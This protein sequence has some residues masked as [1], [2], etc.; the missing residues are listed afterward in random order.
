MFSYE[1][2]SYL[3]SAAAGLDR[4]NDLRQLI[5]FSAKPYQLYLATLLWQNC[6]GLLAAASKPYKRFLCSALALSFAEGE[7]LLV[8]GFKRALLLIPGSAA[9]K[10]LRCSFLAGSTY[11]F[12]V[13]IFYPSSSRTGD[14][15]M[16]LNAWLSNA[17]LRALQFRSC[18][19]TDIVERSAGH[20]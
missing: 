1:Q 15:L 5:I 10:I 6:H 17:L 14:Q 7:Q 20:L 16:L 18:L 13:V 11:R 2:D 12:R 19:R 3:F 4:I 9:E 8:G